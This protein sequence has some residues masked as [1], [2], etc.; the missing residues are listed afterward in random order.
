MAED[1][2][3]IN[4]ANRPKSY[5]ARTNAWDDFPNGRWGDGR[6]PAFGELSNSHFFR[7]SVG[8][9]DDRKAMWG[10]APLAPEEVYEVF[11]KY[12]EGSIP[13][14]PW[15]ET[16]VHSETSLISTRLASINRR[17]YMTVN[18]QPAVNGDPSEDAVFGWGG[19]GG[20]VYQK[21]YIEFFCSPDNLNALNEAFKTRPSLCYYAIDHGGN[22]RGSAKQAATALTWGVFPNKEI[23]Q[24][25]IF[26]PNTFSVWSEEAFELWLTWA[27]L[28]DDETD[29]S[30]LIHDIH[31]TYFLVAVVDNDFQKSDI[32]SIFDQIIDEASAELKNAP[33]AAAAPAATDESENS[34][35]LG[36]TL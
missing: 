1:V 2:R 31:D 16:P 14:L 28:F 19:A 17:G 33:A 8:S 4:W 10:E 34:D 25:T 6:S 5:V 32:Y 26:D 18:S 22:R 12:V 15:C 11:A 29:S 13:V 21:A 7:P 23:L 9:K 27:C 20:Y 24:P 30:A 35:E 36:L 3:P